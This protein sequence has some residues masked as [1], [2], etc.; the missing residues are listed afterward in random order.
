MRVHYQFLIRDNKV[1]RSS[2]T[3]EIRF[4]LLFC[5]EGSGSGTGSAQTLTDPDPRGL[6][7]TRKPAFKTLVFWIL[8]FS[9]AGD[10]AAADA[11]GQRR[12]RR[13]GGSPPL[14]GHN[15]QARSVSR[16]SQRDV[17]YLCRPIAPLV[18]ESQC[19]GM[20]GCGV[21]ANEY[22]CAHHVTWSPN[23]LWGSTSIFNLQYLCREGFIF[24]PCN[25]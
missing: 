20:G 11:G 8:F 2:S 18:Y 17:V 12:R 21:S 14:Q 7:R 15:A 22:S 19:G 24:L 1:C 6:I 5:K 16:W 3:M 25:N 10:A 13:G 4:Y 23:K 9:S